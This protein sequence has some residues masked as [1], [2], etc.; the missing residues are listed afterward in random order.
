MSIDVV[1]PILILALLLNFHFLAATRVQALIVSVAAQGVLLGLVFPVA[2]Q[3]TKH[4]SGSP[5]AAGDQGALLI[6]MVLL[7]LAIVVIKG[8]V[9]PKMLF[10]GVR[11]A[12]VR[13][14]MESFI[15]TAPTLLLGALGTGLT[16]AFANTLP[17]R[18]DHTSVLVVPAALAT[19][20]I[21]FLILTTQRQALTQVLGYLV[22]ENGI[23]IFGL[24]LVGA[25]PDLV[26]LGVLLDL[27]VGVF[28]MGIIIHHVSREF[29]AATSDHLSA[30]R[31]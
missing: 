4:L 21:G 17:L 2:H 9:I 11:E 30:L 27:F 22:L 6:R 29:P 25:M 19:V 5:E 1:D 31:E 13:G 10:R 18:E 23:F 15:G 24:L 12:G 26:E 16:L 8:Y 20:L 7:T 14:R 3:G 28:V